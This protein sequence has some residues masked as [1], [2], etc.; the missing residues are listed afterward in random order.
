M[1]CTA[2]LTVHKVKK[3]ILE[4]SLKELGVS[5]KQQNNELFS[6]VEVEMLLTKAFL[7]LTENSCGDECTQVSLNWLLRCYDRCTVRP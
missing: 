1:K 3:E 5:D 7:R 6:V 4:R 2:I